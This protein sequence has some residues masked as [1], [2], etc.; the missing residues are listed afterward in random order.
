MSINLQLEE[1]YIEDKA[2]REKVES[3]EEVDILIANT[4]VRLD[5][6]RAILPTLDESEIWNCHYV[7]YLLQ[8]GEGSADFALAHEYAKKAVNMGSRVTKWL[9][10]ATLDRLLISHG[11]LQ[12]FGTQYQIIGGKKVYAPTD[13]TVTDAEKKEYGVL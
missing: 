8:H 6:L 4:K 2:E 10:A 3:K 11:K 12:K 1:L 7:A 9:Y 13:K 5:K